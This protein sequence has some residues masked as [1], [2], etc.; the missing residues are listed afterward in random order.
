[1]DELEN[2][3]QKLLNT[4]KTESLDEYVKKSKE[5]KLRDADYKFKYNN[6]IAYPDYNDPHFN[7]K[8]YNKK[9]F[10]KNKSEMTITT[11]DKAVESKCDLKSFNLTPNQKFIKTFISPLT[12]Y[13]S[14]LLYHGVGV[15]KCHAKDTPIIMFDGT[16]KM[17]QDIK[18]G[19]LLMGD[20]STPRK[21]LSLAQGIDEMY[22][23]IPVKGDKYTVNSEHI[24]C[25]KRTKL[26]VNKVSSKT[27]PFVA[28]Y[29]NTKTG[30]TTSKAFKTKE[31]AEDFLT[32]LH[33]GDNILEIPVKDYLKLSNKSIK[34]LK[35]YRAGI[36]FKKKHV[37]IDPYLIG[38]WLG[39]G[40]KGDPVITTQDS[41]VLIYLRKFANENNLSL[42]YQG[43]YD[44]NLSAQKGSKNV[45]L[46]ALHH[47]DLINN[48]HIP[49]EYKCNDRQIRL[50]LLAGLIDSA[51]TTGY[52]I[53]QKNKT[54]AE[55]I[56]Y[57]C[58]SLG[59]GAY[60]KKSN[61]SCTYKGK[62][63][64]GLYYR[65]YISGNN[66]D[67][68]PVKCT[69]KVA[70]EK[71]I[72]KDPLLT[73]ITVKHVGQDNYYGFTL[74]GNNR[75]LLGDFTVTHNT[76][77]AI[78]IAEQ[79]HDM[80]NKNKVLVILSETLT[81]NFKKQIFDITKYDITTNLSKNCTGTRYPDKILNNETMDPEVLDKKITELINEKYEF[82]GYKEIALNV[83]KIKQNIEDMIIMDN[84]YS[85]GIK[86]EK[87]QKMKD[88]LEANK[89]KDNY[90]KLFK[91]LPG[92]YKIVTDHLLK[93][94]KNLKYEEI[95]SRLIQEEKNLE[96]RVEEDFSQKISELFSNRLIIID[97]AHNI[98]N[99][100]NIKTKE[101]ETKGKIKQSAEVFDKILTNV[102]NVKLI[103]LTATPMFNDA[104]EIVWTLNLLLKNDKRTPI[105]ENEIFKNGQIDEAGLMKVARGYVS[106]MRGENPFSFPFRLS[107]RI[108]NDKSIMNEYPS[109]D[110]NDVEIEDQDQIKYL[111]IIHSQMSENQYSVY[112]CYKTNINDND[113]DEV[114]DEEEEED[115]EKV[116]NNFNN[117]IQISNIVYSKGDCKSPKAYYGS[118]GLKNCFGISNGKYI[119]K[120]SKHQILSQKHINDYAPKIGKILNYV[121][122]SQGIVFIYSRFYSSG[123]IPMA[124]ALEHIGFKK[125]N[126][127][128]IT[129]GNIDIDNKFGDSSPQYVILSTKKEL[130]PNNAKEI[131]ICKS[132]ENM[133]G[134]K[135]K[136]IIV[137]MI[138]TEG[139]DFKNIREVHILEP[140]FNLNRAEQITGRA[141][142]YCSHIG[143]PKSLR[144]VTIYY[145]A[146]NY[147]SDIEDIDLRTYR[148][149]EKKQLKIAS[150]EKVLKEIAVDCN[151]NIKESLF[152]V[153]DL[154]IKF[155]IT[156]SQNKEIQKYKVGDKD[157]SSI[158]GYK[159][160]EFK[161]NPEI[162][163]FQLDESTFDIYYIKD[164]I[165]MYKRYIALLYNEKIM[166]MSY[167][168]ILKKL[169]K[170]YLSID[171]NIVSYALNDMLENKYKIKTKKGYGYLIY[172]SNLYIIQLSKY[173]DTKMTLDEREE[174]VNYK[175]FLKI[176]PTKKEAVAEIKESST[177]FSY[178][179]MSLRIEQNK[180]RF[181]NNID[182][183]NTQVKKEEENVINQAI[184]DYTIDYLKDEEFLNI[185]RLTLL[186]ETSIDIYD[187]FMRA[188][189]IGE[190][191]GIKL[192]Y[193]YFTDNYYKLEDNKLVQST[194]FDSGL[195]QEFKD[196]NSLL[197]NESI[198]RPFFLS[199]ANKNEILF[200][201]VEKKEK[202]EENKKTPKAKK[203]KEPKNSIPKGQDCT[204]KT[205]ETNKNNLEKLGLME[206]KF[207]FNETVKIK[208]ID[209]CYIFEI[210]VR[211]Y[212]PEDFSR[213][214][215]KN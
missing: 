212:K 3:Y 111:D 195:I 6:Y 89:K 72:N 181:Y 29:I 14:L 53:I 115:E 32:N 79:Y 49:L 60:L 132:N 210:L 23:I 4:Y 98:R 211:A 82:K 198:K 77:T 40:S 51:S 37:K 93:N 54:L 81:V 70:K 185:T 101:T 183:L 27:N 97:E 74:D 18:V 35:G 188:N 96:K 178:K 155:D 52:E 50:A 171:D 162:K 174:D 196:R 41:K 129:S 199:F 94:I 100:V 215:K 175:K 9:E 33:K 71:T 138:A 5:Y 204:T 149:A 173:L 76:C 128:S 8:I 57:L 118:Q 1:M 19:E 85:G 42:N 150:V 39:D 47:Y 66:F 92:G 21:V 113:L 208:K 83:E 106:Y 170:I 75:Y 202:E 116:E 43:H 30:K 184:L 117:T 125:Y 17:V 179:D 73:G 104:K 193:D 86:K 63:V 134:N 203:N 154:N 13:N 28:H 84:D 114:Y 164:E 214:H 22:D 87:N 56:V 64:T 91:G 140:W 46:D 156:T 143:L 180:K 78:S 161:C 58:R 144:N 7:K 44:Y 151:L 206:G 55:D 107:P 12:P 146:C 135:V 176:I 69:R 131:A 153:E 108:N 26:G 205:L 191:N 45:F 36:E 2:I 62:K 38:F 105:K 158:C 11:F 152:K 148:K 200:K 139:L 130:S 157:F 182:F 95:A 124:I 186:N 209:M 197:V 127:T 67:E 133:Y 121:Q 194:M 68:I 102:V 169:E 88:Y 99:P 34:N 122:N 59:Y 147:D 31:E 16:I 90:I 145:H 192:L 166:K 110:Y 10:N 119:Y 123:I 24:L 207:K 120:N 159:K 15:G 213:H 25:L 61:K 80:Y 168:T 165:E 201:I 103:L 187:S 48:K 126:N 160:C 167:D 189:R 136:V 109:I 65:C 177:G 163:K 20:D 141:V 190:N 172:S 142:R 112:N 137:S